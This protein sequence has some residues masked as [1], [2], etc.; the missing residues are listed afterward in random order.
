MENTPAIDIVLQVKNELGVITDMANAELLKSLSK[1]RNSNHPDKFNDETA[2]RTAEEKFKKLSSLLQLFQSYLEQKR[3]ETPSS[4]IVQY[5]N[6][7]QEIIQVNEAII[8]Q[9]KINEL[10]NR[11]KIFDWQIKLKDSQIENLTNRNEELLEQKLTYS[12]DDLSEIYKPKKRSIFIN[13]SLLVVSVLGSITKIKQYIV[14]TISLSE[15]TLNWIF[16]MI[17]IFVLISMLYR[18]I[19]NYRLTILSDKFSEVT[20]LKDR[21]SIT[22]T[23][24]PYNTINYIFE[25]DIESFIE[26]EIKQSVIDKF[27]FALKMP[28]IKKELKHYIV[29]LLYEKK[30]I[31]TGVA[32]GFDRRFEVASNTS[33]G[34]SF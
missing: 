2:K 6:S 10:E 26:N 17:I 3:A 16:G 15:S 19:S 1:A 11:I 18:W 24:K 8:L 28:V 23:V 33:S 20:F 13:V 9:D 22:G 4:E 31:T 27:L 30:T 14:Q 25:S 29:S 5:N 7:F 32:V 12:K 34:Y 21:I